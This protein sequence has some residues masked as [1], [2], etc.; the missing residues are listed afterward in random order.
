MASSLLLIVV[1]VIVGVVRVLARR[2]DRGDSDGG[3]IPYALLAVAVGI[4]I[5]ALA[6]LGKG[7]LPWCEYHLFPGDESGI[8]FGGTGSRRSLCVHPLA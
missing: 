4:T 8:R 3:L 7:R 2:K 1:G 6:Q 5:F